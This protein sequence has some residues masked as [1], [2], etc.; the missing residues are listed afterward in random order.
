[1]Q[2]H[3][4]IL[5]IEDLHVE[6]R[7][8]DG[9]VNALRGIDLTVD[10]GTVL[11]VVG[12]SGCGK[13][14]TA[15]SVMQLLPRPRGVITKGRIIF[16]RGTNGSRDRLD[17]TA[18][19]PDGS[20]MRTIRGNNIAM[21]FQEPMTSLNPVY[22]IGN[23]ILEVLKIH[24]SMT[25]AEAREHS[26]E[27]LRRVGLPKPENVFES[28]PHSL[29]GGMRQR[30]VIAMAFSCN[31]DLLLADEPTTALDV[32]TQAKV[33]DIMLSLQ[34]EFN[35]ST[36]LITHDLGVIAEVTKRVAVMYL[37][38]IVEEAD[39]HDLFHRAKHPYTEGLLKSIPG[40][41]HRIKQKLRPI[42]G[43]VPDPYTRIDGCAF[44]PRCPHVM[45]KCVFE[46]PPLFPVGDRHAARCWLH[47]R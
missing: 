21:V 19:K 3:D 30:A 4:E 12:E 26:V 33:L 2:T 37:G 35:M 17:I 6:F 41:G 44:A 8:E 47:G 38:R 22:T 11:G 18:L 28:Y 40:T 5:R 45:K 7:T 25:A 39:V 20:E 23:Q 10:R 42:R 31:P 15:T 32:T 34:H 43:S 13:S 24:T 1:M 9:I 14:V 36:V 29:S 16:S 46:E 27:M